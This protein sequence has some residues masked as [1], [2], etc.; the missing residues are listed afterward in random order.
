MIEKIPFLGVGLGY[1]PELHDEIMASIDEID[2]L[3][4]ITDH[5]IDMPP[6]KRAEA[7]ALAKHF[8]LVLH[9]VELSIGTEGPIDRP[10]LEKVREVAKWSNAYWVSDHLCFTGVPGLD[11]AQLTPLAFQKEIAKRTAQKAYE[12][13]RYLDQPFLLENI[14][15][16]FT[17]PDANI[18]EAELINSIITGSGA[19]LLLDLANVHCNASNHN[20]DPWAFLD[21]LPLERVIQIHVAGGYPHRGLLLDAHSHAVHDEVFAML[22]YIAPRL[23]NLKGVLLERDQDYPPIEHLIAEIHQLKQILLDHWVPLHRKIGVSNAPR[24]AYE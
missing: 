7:E 17:I 10:Y 16:Y 6:H 12:A 13:M 8:P 1:R 5:Y 22:K 4:L 3:E 24:I 18:T 9:G 23:T 19:F 14:A 2:F 15:Y 21:Q 11:L 20:Y